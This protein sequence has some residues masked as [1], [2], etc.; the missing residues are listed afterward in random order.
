MSCGPGPR[1]MTAPARTAT[2]SPGRGVPPSFSLQVRGVAESLSTRGRR[3]LVGSFDFADPTSLF[4]PSDEAAHVDSTEVL[5]AAQEGLSHLVSVDARFEA[6]G[7]TLFNADAPARELLTASENVGVDAAISSYLRAVSPYVTLKPAQLTLEHLVRRYAVYKHNFGSLMACLLPWH[8]TPLFA[9][10]VRLGRLSGGGQWAWLSGVAK[11]GVPPPRRIISRQVARDVSLLSFLCDILAHSASE[12]ACSGESEPRRKYCELV[13]SFW[14]AVLLDV[15][16]LTQPTEEFVRALLPQ[17]TRGLS[18]AASPNAR[19]ACCLVASALALRTTLSRAAVDAILE[20]VSKRG[21]GTSAAERRQGLLCATAVCK[22]QRVPDLSSRAIKRLAAVSSLPEELAALSE[23]FDIS[24]LLQPMLRGWVAL[25][26]ADPSYAQGLKAVALHSGWPSHAFGPHVPHLTQ[27]LVKQCEDDD[28]DVERVSLLTCLSQRFPKEVG[29]GLSLAS[30][31]DNHVVSAFLERALASGTSDLVGSSLISVPKGKSGSASDTLSMPIFLALE[32]PSAAVRSCA[33][34]SLEKA[35]SG[36]SNGGE[37]RVWS[38][39]PVLSSALVRRAADPEPTVSSKVLCSPVLRE[40]LI[41][42]IM[43]RIGGS[44][45]EVEDEDVDDDEEKFALRAASGKECLGE[46][47]AA[48]MALC[49]ALQVSSHPSKGAVKALTGMAA[50]WSEVISSAGSGDLDFDVGQTPS[51]GTLAAIGL[52]ELLPEATATMWQD[53]ASALSVGKSA[54]AAVAGLNRPH[55]LLSN[56]ASPGESDSLPPSTLKRACEVGATCLS[57][58]ILSR[59]GGLHLARRKIIYAA[60]G[61]RLDTTVVESFFNCNPSY[62]PPLHTHENS[63]PRSWLRTCVT[64]TKSSS[65]L[66][67]LSGYDAPLRGRRSCAPSEGLGSVCSA[68]QCK[69]QCWLS[70]FRFEGGPAGDAAPCRCSAH[71]S[72]AGRLCQRFALS[73]NARGSVPRPPRVP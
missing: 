54:A 20:S 21:G 47:I 62:R 31:A 1:G 4:P 25:I 61:K 66:L 70:G 9:A 17:L 28:E 6:F 19:A 8:D 7:S 40:A 71:G 26:E 10:V 44:G 60:D 32:H 56:L 43:G 23:S 14:S 52:I 12:E 63:P 53:K 11:S 15:M 42:I 5:E 22:G 55:P 67:L 50:L 45:E 24:A 48:E 72:T 27:L 51:A 41:E 58:Y 29:M 64:L 59:G 30:D 38:W 68:H 35:A 33:V 18:A 49:K 16:D 46:L 37:S 34:K 57:S 3:L 69:A 73:R 39:G 36:S 13:A 65:C 2:C